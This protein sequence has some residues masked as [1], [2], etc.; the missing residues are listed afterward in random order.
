MYRTLHIFRLLIMISK[1]FVRGKKAD[2]LFFLDDL[3]RKCC[4]ILKSDT[5]IKPE[6]GAITFFMIVCMTTLDNFN[7]K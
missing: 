2:F 3:G 4:V 6:T 1:L 7:S 5:F